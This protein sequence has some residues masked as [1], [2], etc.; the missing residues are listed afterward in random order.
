MFRALAI[1]KHFLPMANTRSALKRVRQTKVRTSRNRV[2]KNRVKDA[3]KAVNA[4]AEAGDAKAAAE[5]YNKFASVAD[6]AAKGGAM[7]SRT[8][9]R[10]KSRAAAKVAT[11]SA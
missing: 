6:K 4:A 9:S 10:L 8:A 5:A 7:H 2:L 11:A 3:R 1:S